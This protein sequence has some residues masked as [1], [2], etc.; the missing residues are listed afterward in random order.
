MN[1]S[2][3]P[4]PRGSSTGVAGRF[5]SLASDPFTDATGDPL[6]P[7]AVN[8]DGSVRPFIGLMPEDNTTVGSRL[9]V[10]A[11]ATTSTL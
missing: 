9:P 1:F 10:S 6:G 8:R 3:I 5:D 2:S 7:Q 11:I 4:Q